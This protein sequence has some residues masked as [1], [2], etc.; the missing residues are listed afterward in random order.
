MDNKNKAMEV[1]SREEILF[2][3]ITKVT[4]EHYA[5]TAAISTLLYSVWCLTYTSSFF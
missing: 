4:K 5:I 2:G 1:T 3:R